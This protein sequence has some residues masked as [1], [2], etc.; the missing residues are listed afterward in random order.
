M[1]RLKASNFELIAIFSALMTRLSV[2]TLEL[3]AIFLCES[4]TSRI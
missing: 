1:T 4:Q 2:L 3:I